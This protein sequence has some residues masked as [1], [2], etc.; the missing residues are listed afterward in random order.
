MLNVDYKI[1]AKALA[2][3]LK[4]VLPQIIDHDQTGF[5]ANRNI[6]SNIRRAMEVAEFAREH[7][8]PCMLMS[9]DY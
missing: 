7:Q 9:I 3:R 8:V 6:S 5:M 1:L 2:T 4:K